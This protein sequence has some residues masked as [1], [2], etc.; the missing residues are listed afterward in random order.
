MFFKNWRQR[1]E[2]TRLSRRGIFYYNV[3]KV[4][5]KLDPLSAYIRLKE[6]GVD[7]M[8]EDVRGLLRGD[9]AKLR[10]F[11]ENVQKAFRLTSYNETT[12]KGV[13][14]LDCIRIYF[15]FY[16]YLE[17]LKK[18]V[19]LLRDFAPGL[20]QRLKS[21]YE[22]T[23]ERKDSEETSSL[24]GSTPTLQTRSPSQDLQA[25]TEQA[26]PSEE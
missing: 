20:E 19:T 11:T 12:G 23:P 8:S 10:D 18:N 1:N 7:V 2:I 25:I 21:L 24:L 4:T 6:I 9:S 16:R 17:A 14:C 15:A 26:E 13:T 22:I 3:G 5:V